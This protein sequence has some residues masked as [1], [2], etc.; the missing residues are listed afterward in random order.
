MAKYVQLTIPFDYEEFRDIDNYEG[1]Y[2]ISNFG[3]VY[4][5]KRN[6]FLKPCKENNKGYLVVILCK[7]DKPK[8]YKIHRLVA[9][10]FIPNPSNLPQI[11]HKDENKANNRVENLEWC[12]ASY[13]CN[14]G[15]RTAR[16]LSKTLAHPNW[17]A[18]HEKSGVPKKPVLQFT[19]EGEF[20]KEYP[21]T[22]E[23]SRQTKIS[24]GSISMCCLEKRKSAGN[25]LW[26][27]KDYS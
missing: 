8:K 20:V 5:V 26:K 12:T 15:T 7:D 27:F 6:K 17:K 1:L 22:M 2:K 14:Y 19:R 10:A 9:Q 23:A 11:N 18:S 16:I 4:S 24:Q 25:Y 13:N 21:S 3:R